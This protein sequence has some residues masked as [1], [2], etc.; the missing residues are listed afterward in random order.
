M[1]NNKRVDREEHMSKMKKNQLKAATKTPKNNERSSMPA[2]NYNKGSRGKGITESHRNN[3]TTEISLEAGP[4]K[5]LNNS[6][7][8][9]TPSKENRE[10]FKRPLK[11]IKK[12]MQE[13]KRKA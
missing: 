1:L 5:K 3:V 10:Y 6:V 8:L 2:L 9:P 4:C 12:K 13:S 7:L 11:L